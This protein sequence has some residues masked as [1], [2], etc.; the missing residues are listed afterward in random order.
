MDPMSQEQL[1]RLVGDLRWRVG[2]VHG[3]ISLEFPE[4]Y[5]YDPEAHLVDVD[6]PRITGLSVEYPMKTIAGAIDGVLHAFDLLPEGLGLP[7]GEEPR[8]RRL[9]RGGADADGPPSACGWMTSCSAASGR[10]RTR[11]G[12]RSPRSSARRW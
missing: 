8:F 10:R 1:D 6:V 2:Q 5:I 3:A 4:G 7:K 9:L 11:R 12:T